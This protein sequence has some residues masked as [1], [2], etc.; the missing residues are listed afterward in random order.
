MSDI[1]QPKFKIGAVVELNSG[2]PCMTVLAIL[3]DRKILCEW[4]DKN[5]IRHEQDFP[6]TNVVEFNPPMPF[7]I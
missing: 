6:E 5:H 1:H 2:G 4:F 7:S 3:G